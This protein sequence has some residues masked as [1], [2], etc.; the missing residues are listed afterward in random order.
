MQLTSLT[1]ANEGLSQ[2]IT[3]NVFQ[4]Q[5]CKYC[6]QEFSKGQKLRYHMRIHT[7]DGLL[8][9][10]VCSKVFTNS[11]SLKTHIKRVHAKVQVE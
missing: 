10:D 11:Y 5:K 3:L 8:T 2:K 1:A 7:G 6:G 4:L 9:C